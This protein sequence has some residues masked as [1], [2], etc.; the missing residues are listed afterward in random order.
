MKIC[1]QYW[2]FCEFKAPSQPCLMDPSTQE[3]LEKAGNVESSVR[4]CGKK[5]S[6]QHHAV[7][8]GSG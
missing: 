6:T 4:V 7:G 2:T 3:G 8:F 1:V 5:K